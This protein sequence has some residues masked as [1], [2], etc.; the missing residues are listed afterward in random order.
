VFDAASATQNGAPA[1]LPVY[2]AAA[3]NRLADV[4]AATLFVTAADVA[5]PEDTLPDAF[6]TEFYTAPP[7]DW[8]SLAADARQ[9]YKTQSVTGFRRM[10]FGLV[11]ASLMVLDAVLQTTWSLVLGLLFLGLTLALCFAV[12]GPFAGSVYRI[13]I[14]IFNVLVSSWAVSAVQGVLIAYLVRIAA[15][16]S[17]TAVIAMSGF[18]LF[19]HVVFLLGAA[20]VGIRALFVTAGSTMPDA[21]EMAGQAL[22]T[23]SGGIVGGVAGALA[24]VNGME[25]RGRQAMYDMGR[26]ATAYIG[27][28]RFGATP[29]YALGVALAPSDAAPA[30]AK[31]GIMAGVLD[32]EGDLNQGIYDG[33]MRAHGNVTSYRAIMQQTRRHRG[34]QPLPEHR[35]SPPPNVDGADAAPAPPASAPPPSAQTVRLPIEVNDQQ[36]AQGVP[37]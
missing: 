26:S 16:G 22:R 19:L 7:T 23:A 15:T 36:E 11:P 30:L 5:T 32:P 33:A 13:S 10:F 18:V 35:A 34:R 37:S 9:A 8:S 20:L 21:P 25:Q 6:V 29:N 27:A 31:A 17:A 14:M 12:F 1:A 4:A 2:D 28:R 24:G 3:P